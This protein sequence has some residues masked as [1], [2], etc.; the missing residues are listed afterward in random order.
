MIIILVKFDKLSRIDNHSE[1]FLKIFLLLLPIFT[2]FRGYEIFT[3][4]KDYFI[5][6]YAIILGNIFIITNRK[7]RTIMQIGVILV[8]FL[9]FIKFIVSFDNGAMMPYVSYIFR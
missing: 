3:R 1:F 4:F 6:S 7:Y 9:G 8:C 2:I 5:L